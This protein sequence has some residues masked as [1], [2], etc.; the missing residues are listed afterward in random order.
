MFPDFKELLSALN[1]H[2]AKYLIVGAY[3]VAIHSQPRATKDLDILVRADP[4]NAKA[5]Y[6]ALAQFGAPLA[7]VTSTDFAEA[8]PFF[9]MGHEPIA[10]DILT[11]IPGLEFDAAWMRR[12]ESVID[13]AVGLSAFFIS[14]DDLIA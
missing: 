9:R 4:E 11:E 14:K 12:F 10:V 7:D 3:A 6:A 8:G 5:V 13:E 2:H 1:A